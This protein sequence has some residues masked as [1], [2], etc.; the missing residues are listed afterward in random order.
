M[1]PLT[2]AE[3]ITHH[4]QWAAT[5]TDMVNNRPDL[6]HGDLIDKAKADIIMSLRIAKSLAMI[7]DYPAVA[8]KVGD[9]LE[10]ARRIAQQIEDGFKPAKDPFDG[11]ISVEEAAG[12]IDTVLENAQGAL[13]EVAI[14]L[15]P[16]N[17]ETCHGAKGGV[18]GNEN[19]RD[20]KRICDY[21]DAAA[22]R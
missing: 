14:K 15:E 22:P 17:C 21:C 8:A 4:R 5:L 6:L 18:K 16:D 9:Y 13:C 11:Y 3:M 12:G 19:I 2:I 1:I 20:G 10:D 7:P